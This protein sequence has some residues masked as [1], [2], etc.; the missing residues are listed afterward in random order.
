MPTKIARAARSAAWRPILLKNHIATA[1][2]MMTSAGSLAL[3]GTKPP[4]DAFVVERLR[5]AGA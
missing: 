1:D 4:K 5:E 2:K 3:A